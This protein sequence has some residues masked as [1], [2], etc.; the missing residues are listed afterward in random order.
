MGN[1]LKII[2]EI[3]CSHNGSIKNLKKL[4]RLASK[5]RA[6]IV[7]LQIW[8]LDKM[9]TPNNKLFKRIKNIEISL[10]IWI[11]IIKYIKKNFKKIK[12]YCCFY[13][14]HSFKI[15]DKVKIDGI[16]INSSDLSNPILLKTALKYNL[17]I[18]L[19]VGGSSLK[20]ID[21]ALNILRKK[22]KKNITLMYGVQNFPTKLKDTNLIRLVELRNKFKID[23][24]YQDHSS[25]K[26][27]YG[28]HLSLVAIGMGVKFIEQHITLDHNKK[29]FDHQS[30]MTP[31]NFINFVNI[32]NLIKIAYGNK[33]NLKF[34][35]SDKKY[36]E[37]Q[38]KSIVASHNLNRGDLITMNNI[39]ILRSTKLGLA[40]IDVSQIINK[41]IKKNKKKYEPIQI[42][43]F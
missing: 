38:K 42:T 25:F 41:K 2:A 22:L 16:K 20:E 29:T 40:P 30:A 21:F 36:R 3:A 1:N 7:Q 17:P 31:K 32:I 6:D 5:A 43:D 26:T 34:N 24:G 18:N 9:M 10:K 12:I 15:L 39:A 4:I 13:E 8:Q 23:I 35:N 27:D 11:E 33:F 14:H 37:F 28:K 19:S